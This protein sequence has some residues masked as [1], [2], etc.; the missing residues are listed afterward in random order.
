MSKK[1][2]AGFLEEYGEQLIDNGYNIVPIMPGKKAPGFDGWQKTQATKVLLKDWL[3]SGYSNSGVGVLTKF[4]PAVDIDVRD[5]QA[6]ARI[7]EWIIE[8]ISGAPTRVG[9]HP[10]RLMLFRTDE[11]FKKMRSTV[12]VDEF[13]DEH[14]VEILADGQQF[15]AYH[16]HPQTR[17]PYE[18]TTEI[19]PLNTPTDQLPLLTLDDAHALIAFFEDLA[20][21]FQWDV[22]KKARE[23]AKQIDLDNPWAE[24]TA[25]IELSDEEIRNRLLLVRNPDDHDNWVNIGM[26]LYHQFDGDETGLQFWHEW[27]ETADNYD[28]EA[29]DRRWE[30][31]GI[32]GKG[33]AP[34]TARLILKL[35]AEAI[36][37]TA[38]ELA[39]SLRDQFLAA[40]DAV[41]WGKAANATR[42]AEIDAITRSSLV[43]IAKESRER[44]SGAKI[45]IA[46]I[47]KALSFAPKRGEKT[48]GWCKP[49]VY[50]VTDDK[51]FNTSSKILTSQQGFNAMYDREAMTKKDVLDGKS[52]PSSN[53]STLALNLYKIPAIAGR[54]YEPGQDP[55]F[56]NAEGTF[57]NTYREHEIPEVSEDYYPRDIRNIKLVKAHISHLIPDKKEARLFLDWLSWVVQN[58]GDHMNYAVLL[59]GVEG[60]G[61]SFFAMLLRAVMGVSNVKMIN[62][63]SL[64]GNFTDWTVGQCV[65][66]VEEVRLIKHQNKYEI[67]NRIKPFITN[68]IIEV[69][70]KG[71]PQYNAKNTSNY[72]LFSN[73]KDALPL[74]DDGRRYLVLFSQWQFKADLDAFKAENPG[75]Y[76]ALYRTFV[77]SAGALR[78][79]FLSLEQSEEFNPK[80]D[81]PETRAKKYM[82]RMSTPEFI[83]NVKDVI[84]QG[85]A[86]D[87]C[88]EL[89][90][91]SVL[92]DLII[93]LGGDIPAPKAVA[94]MLSRSGWESIGRIRIGGSNPYFYSKY[95]ERFRY[96]DGSPIVEN[97][98]SALRR[99]EGEKGSGIDDDEI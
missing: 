65:T 33:R 37:N 84:S 55:I 9:Q 39:V 38:A 15:V 94:S 23:A 51:F 17:L 36:A 13:G 27:S 69:H 43:A 88:D 18:W 60:D 12:Y 41:E 78:K 50:D 34:I 3:K 63:Q 58:P 6:A 57:A 26:A 56:M 32:D 40:R 91:V 4:T 61:K 24:D 21:E 85:L 62:A 74:D 82:V 52:S 47:K 49:W 95:P 11:T 31:F 28:A 20:V 10:K 67:I 48:P 59:Q 93:G 92:C 5:G 87:V 97:V 16:I 22:K 99:L 64:E 80:G 98:K 45:P 35:A 54:R 72:L 90:N 81:A 19:E 2:Y 53:A 66:C 86:Y 25:P 8:N 42:E 44:I 29:L 89:L 73:F 68:D 70:P 46:E 14:A 79:W 77:E 96:E 75:Y 7:E 76:M 30:S 1:I 71:K 83:L